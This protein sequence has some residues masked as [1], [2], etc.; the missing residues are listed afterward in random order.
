M[1]AFLQKTY[2][3]PTNQTFSHIVNIYF[4]AC[5]VEYL[6]QPEKKSTVFV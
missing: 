4:F 2:Q 3:L 6:P 1:E 5:F